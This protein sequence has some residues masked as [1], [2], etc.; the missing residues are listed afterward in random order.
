M[1]RSRLMQLTVL[2]LLVGAIMAGLWGFFAGTGEYLESLGAARWW[3]LAPM[4]GLTVVSLG[5]RFIRWHYLLRR[6]DV[7][8]PVRAN[9]AIYFASLLGLATPG[10]V[11][12]LIRCVLMKRRFGVPLRV[13]AL[14][15]FYERLF[16]VA[17]LGLI[18]AVMVTGSMW[19]VMVLIAVSV[20]PIGVLIAMTA[21]R[22]GV[23]P[24]VMR[25]LF[26][27]ATIAIT[28]VMSLGAWALPGFLISLGLMMSVGE[29]A[30][31]MD[32][33][34]TL[35]LMSVGES[36][37]W[38][39]GVGTFASSTL[40]GNLALMPAGVV[41]TGSVA[42][43]G[44]EEMG[45]GLA[46]AAAVVSLTRLAS[47]GVGVLMGV[48]GCGLMWAEARRAKEADPDRHFDEIADEYA[49][50]FSSHVWDYLLDRKITL[51]TDHLGD[52][53]PAAQVGLDL[54]CGL[55]QQC[56]AMAARGYRVIGLD[57]ALGLLRHARTD[58]VDVV[59]GDALRLPFADGV[60]DFV[61]TVG[62]LHHLEEPGMQE[63]ACA[64]VMRVL[65]PGGLFF[66]HETNPD[67]P[68]FRFYMG[69]VFPLLKRIDMG[70]ERWLEPRFWREVAGLE[71]ATVTHFTFLPDFVP[72]WLLGPASRVERR[73]ERGRL[74]R[75]SVHYLAAMRKPE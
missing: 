1:M 25:G 12:E 45:V 20:V 40:V 4:A 54:G 32:G 64:E 44:L 47:V 57:P 16:D 33:V 48:L 17:A 58:E 62:V 38:M 37:A 5:V 34:G 69:Y 50:Q 42:I 73:L 7:R 30:A 11:G 26:G 39:D 29:S 3:F 10:H 71:L 21:R 63:R 24:V 56:G 41:T 8:V 14:T 18:G 23:G 60:L 46:L 51:M 27:P 35:G 9:L 28:L 72:K 74:S 55:G 2:L 6:A 22:V 36:A 66:V 15:W 19:G 75:Y 13:T 67:N 70:T 49:Q 31:W 65:K 61:Y 43:M 52:R 59:N 53:E 68:L